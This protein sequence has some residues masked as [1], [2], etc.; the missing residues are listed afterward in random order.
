VPP[1]T[2]VD[3]TGAG[4]ALVAGTLFALLGG[5]PLRQAIHT[6]ARAAKLTLEST[7]ACAA[8][9]TP[10]ALGAAG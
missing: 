3:V 7:A 4:D 8:G 9:M 5:T 6:G 10:A 2:P 1:A